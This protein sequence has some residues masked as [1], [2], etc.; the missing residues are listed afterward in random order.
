MS[1]MPNKKTIQG[2]PIYNAGI[3]I[4][5]PATGN[6]EQIL[7]PTAVQIPPPQ[8]ST[9]QV[10]IQPTPSTPPQAE[11]LAESVN[12]T[13]SQ[14]PYNSDDIRAVSPVSNLPVNPTKGITQLPGTDLGSLWSALGGGVKGTLGALANIGDNAFNSAFNKGKTLNVDRQNALQQAELN[15]QNILGQTGLQNQG[16]LQRQ[17]N[18]INFGQNQ[19]QIA[20]QQQQTM[21]NTENQNR[22]EQIRAQLAGE[23]ANQQNL[24]QMQ[25]NLMNPKAIM[26]KAL[27]SQRGLNE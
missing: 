16:A 22:L 3:P 11:T 13:P 14:A 6:R 26:G 15:R 9:Q 1:D 7:P 17:Q 2:L 24:L 18:E 8:A 20:N 12:N 19:Q 21:A 10:K 27:S 4:I 5:N 23:G 25:R